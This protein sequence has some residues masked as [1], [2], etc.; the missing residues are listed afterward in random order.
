MADN[1]DSAVTLEVLSPEAIPSEVLQLYQRAF[2]ARERLPVAD[3]LTWGKGYRMLW[4]GHFCGLAF[5]CVLNDI[6]WLLFFAI[7]EECRGR[8]LGTRALGALEDCY[9]GHRFIIDVEAEAPQ[10]PNLA[11]RHR[12]IAFWRRNGFQDAGFGFSWHGE[13]YAFLVKGGSLT[14]DEVRQFWRR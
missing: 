6:S 9:A 1:G 8:G 3:M 14:Y 10:A 4:R 5:V 2:P 11:E 13:Q 12:R 7:V